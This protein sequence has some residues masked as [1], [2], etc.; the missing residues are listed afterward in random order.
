MSKILKITGLEKTYTSGNKQL[1]VLHDI[2]F[3]VEKGQTFSIIGPSGSGKTTLLG[4][5]A[6]LDQPNAGSVELC[7]QDLN[8]LNEDQRAQLRNKEVGFIFQNFQLL[9]TLT[10]LENV[11][12]PLELQGAKDAKEKSEIL[13]EKVGLG[14]RMH[15]YPS[16]L[17]GGEQQRVALAR[18]FVNSPSILFADEP[19]GNLD[20]ETGEKVIKL[21]FDLNKELGT[22]LII[23]SH[24]LELANRTQQ[25]V[26]LKG[27]KIITNQLTTAL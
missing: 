11:S 8:A 18:A 5:C 24:D 1:T 9:P 12:V 26:R 21:L 16:Q 25:I 13:L 3:E 19:T 4:L 6:G 10:A 22:T 27:G 15:H 17:S 23:I 20:E 14:K 2:S 7:G